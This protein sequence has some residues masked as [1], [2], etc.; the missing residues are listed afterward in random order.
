MVER[1]PRTNTDTDTLRMLCTHPED[2]DIGDKWTIL[3]TIMAATAAPTYFQPYTH[4]SGEVYIDAAFRGHNN[5][6]ELA[7]ERMK[8]LTGHRKEALF[9]DIGTGTHHRTLHLFSFWRNLKITFRM[10]CSQITDTTIPSNRV[11]GYCNRGNSEKT[12]YYLNVEY[13]KPIRCHHYNELENIKDYVSKYVQ[14]R[15]PLFDEIAQ[16]IFDVMSKEYHRKGSPREM[17]D[18]YHDPCNRAASSSV[19][20]FKYVPFFI[21]LVKYESYFPG[22]KA[23]ERQWKRQR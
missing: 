21:V 10:G 16:R 3:Q 4:P 20:F 9:L 23:Q 15:A 6:C 17:Q 14:E 22:N 19:C 11:E 18:R 5:P 7:Y 12:Y 13:P 1:R 2:N 8:N